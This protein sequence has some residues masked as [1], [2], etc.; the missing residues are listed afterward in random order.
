MARLADPVTAITQP[1][2]GTVQVC[3]RVPHLPQ[4]RGRALA[5]ERDRRPLGIV[6]V[7]GSRRRRR[8]DDAGMIS[9][10][11][12]DQLDRICPCRNQP[13]SR[14]LVWSRRDQLL[15]RRGVA[16]CREP[17]ARFLIAHASANCAQI[18]RIPRGLR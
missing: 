17:G 1:G 12:S 4:Q 5:L 11:G 7:I 3:Q 2:R 14:G 18:W 8:L 15:A 10:Q 13:I 9:G 6:L 16:G